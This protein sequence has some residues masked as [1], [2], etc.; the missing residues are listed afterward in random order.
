MTIKGKA[1]T[2]YL[3]E[4]NKI[5]AYT[6][7]DYISYR[8][9]E[10]ASSLIDAKGNFALSFSISQPTYI[11]LMAD[12]AK[13]E[14]IAEPNRTYDIDFLAK[15][16]DAVNTLSIAVPVSMMFN[17]SDSTEINYLMADFSNRY[18]AFLEYN[19][20]LISTKSSFFF[21]RIDT[22]KTLCVQKY[23]AF[24]KRYLN[25]Y[26]DYT[27][28]QLEE[29]ITLKENEKIVEKYFKNKT[30]QLG[31][32]DYMMFFNQFFA[33]TIS[34]FMAEPQ[35]Q[36]EIGKQNFASLMEYFKQINVLA[37]D[38]I[39][40]TFILKSLAEYFRYPACKVS[41]VLAILDQAA[42]Q[43]KAG[44]NR[45]SAENLKKKF[46]VM[47][48]G[49]PAPTL[50][51]QDMDGKTISLSDFKG[52]YVYLNFWTTWCSSCTQ[53]MMM[54]PELK[55]IYGNKIAFV[56]IS[57]D[58]KPE[59]MKNFLKKNSK[60]DHDKNGAGWKFL[61]CDN[62][63]KAKEEF[64]VLTVPTYFLI[65]PKGNILQSPADKPQDI[66]T[67]FIQIKKKK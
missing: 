63:K 43:C 12:N 39:R 11:Y 36:N 17:N 66:D 33:V 61:Y 7:D 14:M 58:K 60:L 18:E 21:G 25:N 32:N 20:P 3:L 55:K 67:T 13:S 16:S 34:A 5:Y 53:E 19:R 52:K 29:S 15:D 38:T 44:E 46:S 30:I 40:E 35:T 2:S 57:V 56:S 45:R 1:D 65:D 48:T 23:S 41:S 49:N 8:E 50:P 59:S 62:Y 10:L 26:I 27:F 28:A 22:M 47:N 64:N 42:T 37:N 24:N 6:Y 9:K 31:N 4:T 54:I 51:F